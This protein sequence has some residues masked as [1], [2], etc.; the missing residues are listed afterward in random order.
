[1]RYERLGEGGLDYLPCR[2]GTSRL[3]FRGPRRS[4]RGRFVAFL[5][6]T[7]TYGK[8]V[9][10]PFPALVERQLGVDCVNLGSVN[11]GIDAMLHDPEVTRICDRADAVVLQLAGAHTLSNRFYTVHRRRNDRFLR[12]STVLQA[13]YPEIDF[14]DVCFTRHL[15]TILHRAGADRFATVQ[16]ELQLA[17]TMRMRLFLE[18]IGPRCLLLWFSDRLPSDTVA[19]GPEDPLGSDPLFVT[20]AMLDELRPLVRGVVLV[21]PGSNA[22][23]QGS[24]GMFFGPGEAAAAAEL[25][26]VL[27]HHDAAVA[28]T[29]TL[30]ASLRSRA[31]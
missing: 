14:S 17:W 24:H 31:S 23:Q 27:A 1:M 4:L 11:A 6:G 15:L 26:G 7:E 30:K 3:C 28:L 5:G 29:E 10:K 2:Y 12:A 20:R 21:R 9:D 25:P 22:R 13:L 16:A 8:F 19:T 18:R